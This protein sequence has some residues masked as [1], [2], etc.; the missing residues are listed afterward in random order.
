MPISTIAGAGAA[1]TALVPGMEWVSIPSGAVALV[2]D[3]SSCA[4]HDFNWASIAFDALALIPGGAALHCAN[5]EVR[6]AGELRALEL[7]GKVDNCLLRDIGVL[8]S[9][10]CSQV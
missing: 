6:A 10:G 1:V 7:L 3:I 5:E 4:A 2:A 9:E 8:K